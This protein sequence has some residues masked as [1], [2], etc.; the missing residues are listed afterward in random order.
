MGLPA[1]KLQ[2]ATLADLERVPSSMIGELIRG[3]LYVFP[4]PGPQHAHAKAALTG[5]L[6]G[7]FQ[8][9]RGGPGGWRIF[10]EPEFLLGPAGEEDDLIPDLAGWR[11]ERMLR[12]PQTAKFTLAPDWVCEVLSPGTMVID[13]AEKMPVYARHGVRH[14][15]LL[16]PLARTLEVFA[17]EGGRWVLLGVHHSDARVRVEPFEAVE[18]E[19]AALWEDDALARTESMSATAAA[20]TSDVSK[21]AIAT[22][23]GPRKGRSRS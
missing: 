12:L 9:G 2:R 13:R 14:L 15:W 5:E 1:E 6:V 18:L 21:A 3:S 17:L 22:K 19:L 8:R 10:D 23:R 16:D 4:R 11:I 7:P 20:P